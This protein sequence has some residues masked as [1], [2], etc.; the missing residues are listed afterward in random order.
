MRRNQPST[1]AQSGS[2]LV[3]PGFTLVEVIVAIGIL[4]IVGVIVGTIFATVGETLTQGR[5]VSNMNRFAARI[6]RVMRQDFD[7]MVRENGFLVIRNQL[8]HTYEANPQVRGVPLSATDGSPR[9]RRIDE[10]MFFSRGEF[11]SARTPL[12]RDMVARGS[13]ARVYYGHG[14]R[15][16]EDFGPNPD[17]PNYMTRSAHPRLDEPNNFTGVR[18]G[19]PSA[20]GQVNPNEFAGDWA[21]LRH[22]TVLVPRS[23]GARQLPET[24]FGLRPNEVQ[25]DHNRVADSSRQ[26]AL[27]PAAQSVFRAIAHTVP[28]ESSSWPNSPLIVI[29]PEGYNIRDTRD[30]AA[31]LV[32]AGGGYADPAGQTNVDES[33]ARP[34]FTSGL[35][36]VAVTDLDEIRTTVTSTWY[37]P[38]A[39]STTVIELYPQGFTPYNYFTETDRYGFEQA[40]ALYGS[41]GRTRTG[42][43]LLAGFNVASG[44]PQAQQMW[45]L[46]ALPSVPFVSA[47]PNSTGFRVRYEPVPPR[48]YFDDGSTPDADARIRRAYEQADQEMLA[49]SVFLPRCTE[50]IVEWSLGIVDR[51]NPGGNPNY[52]Q[53]IWHGLRRYRDN[54]TAGTPGRYDAGGVAANSPDTLFADV[55]GLRYDGVNLVDRPD[56]PDDSFNIRGVLGEWFF[57]DGN[58]P[59]SGIVGS[60]DAEMVHLIRVDQRY[61]L[62]SLSDPEDAVAAE[63]CFGYGYRDLNILNDPEDDVNRPWPWPRFIRVTMRYVDPAEPTIERTYQAEFRVPSTRGEM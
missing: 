49:S 40:R 55:F 10:I 3:A 19:E 42:S 59:A 58:Q 17:S 8:T 24:V 36:D 25:A 26:V 63:Y 50:F 56:F 5:R 21:L 62:A 2:R 57:E 44:I 41:D 48:V 51:R 53:P 60:M 32:G 9:P 47:S 27:G 11:T 23:T 39:G 37:R 34:L 61:N 22:S 18:L 29:D 4:A 7:N 20:L 43:V 6:E 15:V 13:A 54:P 33:R 12:H 31:V 46:D 1:G 16:P 52:G 35:V 38:T 45:M 14:Q 30:G 28:Y